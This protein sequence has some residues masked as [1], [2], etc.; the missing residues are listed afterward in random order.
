[1]SIGTYVHLWYARW[2]F[3]FQMRRLVY[4]LFKGQLARV[5]GVLLF[6]SQVNFVYNAIWCR[7]ITISAT[8]F[9]SKKE[10]TYTIYK[11]SVRSILRRTWFMWNMDELRVPSI[12]CKVFFFQIIIIAFTNQNESW[13]HQ[14]FSYLKFQRKIFKNN[15]HLRVINCTCTCPLFN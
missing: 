8:N 9:I 12:T 14:E 6:Y 10:N 1:M 11:M 3:N 13:S 5:A 7:S 2:V 4:I 15:L